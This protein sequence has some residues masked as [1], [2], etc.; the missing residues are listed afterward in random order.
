MF[1]PVSR[2][3]RL[4]IPAA[5][6]IVALVIGPGL[7]MAASSSVECGQLT[8]YTAPDPLGPTDGELQLGASSPWAILADATI[9]PAAAAALPTSVNTGPTCV[10]LDF[11]DDGAITAVDFAAEGS[12]VGTVDYDSVTTFYLFA[13][14]LIVPTFITDANPGLA[15][16]VVTS[17][18]AGSE[19]SITFSVNTTTGAFTAFD[20]TA[21]FCGTGSVTSGG[22]GQ[23][24]DATI[25]ASVLDADDLDAL[26]GAGSRQTCATIHSVGTINPNTGELS[27]TTDVDIV[28][29]AAGATVTP[30]PTSTAPTVTPTPGS[31]ATLVVW[32]AVAFATSLVALTV[33]RRR[34]AR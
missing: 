34:D 7:V 31:A 19:L 4:V 22:D 11:D 1:V 18:Q 17:Y 20:G 25:P 15:A 14:R 21:A 5:L 29:A 8:A 2:L 16:I 3:T 6:S 28:V 26:E 33:R 13:N 10:A 12:L 23:V 9:S 24:G 27:I 30:P 32:I